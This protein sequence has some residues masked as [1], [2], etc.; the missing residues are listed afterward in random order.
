MQKSNFHTHTKYSDGHNTPTAMIESALKFGFTSL[1]FSDHSYTHEDESYPMSI[2]GQR[3]YWNEIHT[4]ADYY[5]DRIKIY[6][7]IEQDGESC[8]PEY[9]FDYM[10]SSVHE[11]L[12]HGKCYYI[13]SSAEKQRSMVEQC[14]GGSYPDMAKAYF[15]RVTEHVIRQKTDIVGH[16]D[17]ITKFSFMPEND[18]VYIDAAL[19]AVREIIKHCGVFELN[20][21]AIARGLRNVP[22]PASFILDEIKRL[23]GSVIMTSDCHYCEKLT[24]WFEEGEKYLAEHG[25]Q[26][27]EHAAL[28][29]RV[30]NIEIWR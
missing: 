27:E 23:G 25:F 13:D 21:G 7:G 12:Y 9:D 14:F 17:L 29:D 16:F 8:L 22:Y 1:G 11:F 3:E 10:I 24:V 19:E 30:K 5:A 15:E 26:K 2:N 20:T 28:N 6:C 18:P 4:L